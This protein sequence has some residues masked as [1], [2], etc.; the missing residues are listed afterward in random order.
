MI[1]A[2]AKFLGLDSLVV[3][4]IIAVLAGGGIWAWSAHKY[5][6]G[7]SAGELHERQAWEETRKRDLAKQAAKIASDQEKIDQIEAANLAL[8]AQVAEA[9]NA[10]EEAIKAEGA[11][12]KPALPKS[13]SKAVNR[14]GRP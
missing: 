5:N 11:D 14:E 9:Q 4:A 7:W 12:Q 3:Y 2:I 1:G 6:A 13:L 8:Q 10:L